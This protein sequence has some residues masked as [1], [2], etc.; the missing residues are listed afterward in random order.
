MTDARSN[1]SP[2]RHSHV[3]GTHPNTLTTRS[4]LAYWRAAAGDPAGAATAFEQLLT[5]YLRGLGS[6]HPNTLT[7]RSYLA[8]WRGGR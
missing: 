1:A 5:D 6:G 2:L 3:D 8:Y 4:N 7:T